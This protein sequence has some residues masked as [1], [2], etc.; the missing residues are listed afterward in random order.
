MSNVDF[1]G[2]VG[3]KGGFLFCC[4]PFSTLASLAAWVLFVWL[5]SLARLVSLAA[6]VPLSLASAIVSLLSLARLVSL[7]DPCN[8]GLCQCD[9]LTGNAT[10]IQILKGANLGAAS[11][12][13]SLFPKGGRFDS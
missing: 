1:D 5:L 13:Y 4:F 6:W 2:M 12:T 8:Y 10:A 7:A 11:Q 9:H 3:G